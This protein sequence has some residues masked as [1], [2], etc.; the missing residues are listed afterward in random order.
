M[1][2]TLLLRER[3]QRSGLK[4]QFIADQLNISRY[5]L[6]NKIENKSQFKS[7]EI[8]T[9]CELLGIEALSEKECIFF[10]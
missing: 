2:N 4:L 3:I 1:T 7:G 6:N 8:K 10:A 5:A 9:L